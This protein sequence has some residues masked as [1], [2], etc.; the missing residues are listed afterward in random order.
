M[1]LN[2]AQR[3]RIK[4][5][6]ETVVFRHSNVLTDP[7]YVISTKTNQH[8]AGR[9]AA[10]DRD[11]EIVVRCRYFDACRGGTGNETNQCNKGN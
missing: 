9:R 4:E 3:M 7:G 6:L 1:R 2:L 5:K 8:G 11:A 10:I